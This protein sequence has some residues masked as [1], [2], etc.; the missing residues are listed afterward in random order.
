MFSFFLRFSVLAPV[1][2]VS[3]AVDSFIER[4]RSLSQGDEGID[5]HNKAPTTFDA[6]GQVTTGIFIFSR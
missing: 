2:S 6:I 5:T 3:V 1:A 4:G